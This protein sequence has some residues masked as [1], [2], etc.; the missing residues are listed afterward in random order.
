MPPGTGETAPRIIDV[1]LHTPD[2]GR[3]SGA[4]ERGT[5]CPHTEPGQAVPRN[6]ALPDRTVCATERSIIGGADRISGRGA[7][8]ASG[9]DACWGRAALR[10]SGLSEFRAGKAKEGVRAAIVEP[11]RRE[12]AVTAWRAS[13]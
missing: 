3:T 11:R 9:A 12:A 1:P 8:S 10:D 5:A 2:K 13:G 4:E 6:E 7:E